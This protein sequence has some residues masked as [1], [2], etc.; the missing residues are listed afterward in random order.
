[1]MTYQMPCL[2]KAASQSR[3]SISLTTR[4]SPTQVSWIVETVQG[5]CVCVFTTIPTRIHVHLSG[6][7]HSYRKWLNACCWRFS[8]SC[9]A[10]I[11]LMACG[12]GSRKALVSFC[13]AA[14][15]QTAAFWWALIAHTL[16]WSVRARNCR[17][18][19]KFLS[20]FLFFNLFF[21]LHTLAVH[22]TH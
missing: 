11:C 2:K 21:F 3:L 8:A 6:P 17:G 1:M 9:W 16:P 5:V 20:F 14:W 4:K 22:Q 19:H 12:D 15:L 7:F 10:S 18:K 13:F